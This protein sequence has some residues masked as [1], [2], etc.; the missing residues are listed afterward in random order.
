MVQDIRRHRAD[1]APSP[2]LPSPPP[3]PGSTNGPQGHIH[4]PRENDSSPGLSHQPQQAHHSEQSYQ[5]QRPSAEPSQRVM[6]MANL[7]NSEPTE[8]TYRTF[9]HEYVFQFPLFLE[10]Y[11]QP[12]ILVV[13]FTVGWAT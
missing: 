5:Q 1:G 2:E 8:P 6:S 3:T 13:R 12:V 7:I 11:S 9:Y 10:G 4:H